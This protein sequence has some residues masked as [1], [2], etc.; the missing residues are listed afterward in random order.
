ML[1]YPLGIREIQFEIVIEDSTNYG[2]MH[3]TSKRP[4]HSESCSGLSRMSWPLQV[5]L[6][7]FLLPVGEQ[8]G[9]PEQRRRVG[10]QRK[11]ALVASRFVRGVHACRGAGA[12]AGP[13]KRREASAPT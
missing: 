3:S 1:S 13:R 7:P 12:H 5:V 8:R 4:S 10:Q 9:W 11:A 2:K 6:V